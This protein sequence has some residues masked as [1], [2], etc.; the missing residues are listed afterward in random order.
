MA[1]LAALQAQRAQLIQQIQAKGGRAKAPNL[2]ARLVAL[3][4]Q[5][6]TAKGGGA[7]TDTPAPVNATVP[8]VF[9]GQKNIA[10]AAGKT[11]LENLQAS[12]AAPNGLSTA[13]A[14]TL[15]AA[16]TTGNLE[17]DRARIE[18]DV[19]GRLTTGLQDQYKQTREQAAQTLRNKGIPFSDD[20]NSRYQKELGV[21]DRQYADQQLA[22]R[23]TATGMGGQEY[24]RNFDIGQTLRQNEFNLQSGARNQQLGEVTAL[25]QVGVPGTLSFAELQQQKQQAAKDR[26]L[27]KALA[28]IQANTALTIAEKQAQ[29]ARL[30]SGGGGEDLSDSPFNSGL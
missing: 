3:E 12:T 1:D 8:E 9:Q 21:L 22:A 19:Y 10:D 4:A 14:P 18:A 30:T 26:A 2:Q 11:A 29:T 25:S 24:Q 20:P 17:A 16:P 27:Q 7:P 6:R 23:Q 5:I 28:Q 13:F 15:T